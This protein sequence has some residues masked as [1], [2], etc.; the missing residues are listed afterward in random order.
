MR[1]KIVI[2]TC[3]KR[4]GHYPNQVVHDKYVDVVATAANGFP[5]VLP[6]PWVNRAADLEQILAET[7]GVFLTGSPSNIEP[8]HYDGPVYEGTEHDPERDALTL[9]LV[10]GAIERGI[11]VLGICRGFQ[12]INV[13]LG[14]SLHQRV[15][16]AGFHDH[17]ERGET[18]DEMYGPAHEVELLA[19]G[20]LAGIF[21]K[22]RTTVNSLHWQGINRLAD[23]CVVEAKADDG[24]V[25]AFAV[26]RARGFALAVQWHPEWQWQHN[27]DARKLFAAFGDACR[28]YRAARPDRH[29]G[30]AEEG[31]EERGARRGTDQGLPEMPGAQPRQR[32]PLHRMRL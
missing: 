16:E 11:P 27:A 2:P 19:G 15:H 7:D 3:S 6:S 18:V 14:G 22:T 20:C 32:P 23:G 26:D 25:E 12:E 5:W 1:P 24:L 17:R 29:G 4:I 31:A 8:R 21:G 13:A 30:R 9:P 28:Q 10:R